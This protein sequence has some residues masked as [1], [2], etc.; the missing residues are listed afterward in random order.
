MRAVKSVLY[1]ACLLLFPC[2]CRQPP[3]VH[4][5]LPGHSSSIKPPLGQPCVPIFLSVENKVRDPERL[6]EN[7]QHRESIPVFAD[8]QQV[9]RYLTGYFVYELPRV[10]FELARSADVP[11]K[12]LL[13]SILHLSVQ[14]RNT[15]N[16]SVVAKIE[17]RD[18][19]D[20]LVVEKTL[21][22]E[23]KRW[24]GSLKP[25]EYNKALNNAMENLIN[26]FFGDADLM[27]ALSTNC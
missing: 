24:G 19:E 16:A 2:A 17:V 21:R 12:A 18:K 5:A 10:G 4:L 26:R 20:G 8:P 25:L 15:Y 14:E 22:G 13:V 11:C 27:R 9:Q 3:H 7:N 6:G 23:G 1:G